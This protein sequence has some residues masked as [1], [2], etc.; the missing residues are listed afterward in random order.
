MRYYVALTFFTAVLIA[1]LA[2]RLQPEGPPASESL[3][4]TERVTRTD[5][6]V[7][8][9]AVGELDAAEST[10]ISSSV[11]GNRAK[12]IF[13][14]EEGTNVKAGE[15]LV[16]FDPTAFEEEVERLTEEVCE[17]EAIIEAREQVLEWEQN[18]VQRER[19]AAAFEVKTAELDLTKIEKGDGPLELVRLE[20]AAQEAKES[21]DMVEGY[22]RD[23]EDLEKQGYANAA[24]IAQARRKVEEAKSKCELAKQ[25][26]SYY[27]TYVL[28]SSIGKARCRVEKAKMELERIGRGGTLK[29][30]KATA[31]VRLGE[32]ELQTALGKL[33]SADSELERTVIRAPIP[34]MVVLT[35]RYQSGQKRKPRVGD[36]VW[37]NQPLV[38]LPNLSSMIVKTRIREVD[39][40]KVSRGKRAAV[41]VDAYPDLRLRGEVESLG[42]LAMKEERVASA[43]KYFQVILAIQDHDDRLR[44]GMTARVEIVSS[45]AQGVL[46]VPVHTVVLRDDTTYCHVLTTSGYE[47]RQVVCGPRNED[48]VEIRDGLREGELVCLS[49][50]PAGEVVRRVPLVPAAQPSGEGTTHESN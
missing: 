15:V 32:R 38:Y 23:L 35:E 44:P 20:R 47:L 28:P 6:E 49:G 36:S 16:R 9:E 7:A 8:V 2:R 5:L 3:P 42:V 33:K 30:A 12:I 50:P 40:H 46:A 11:R 14:V 26:A 48:L 18:Q 24:E 31:A 45:Q 19:L 27:R 1:G 37:Q 22:L 4:L 10:V 43:E 29:V 21:S 39:L 25:Q 34:G 17:K 13:L 41:H